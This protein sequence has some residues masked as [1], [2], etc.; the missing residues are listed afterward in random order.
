MVA[1]LPSRILCL[2]TD[3]ERAGGQQQLLRIAQD[4][5][6]GGV[7]MVQVRAHQVAPD[8]LLELAKDVVD[9]V[10]DEALVVV[11][12]TPEIAI[13]SGA[14]GVHFRESAAMDRTALPTNLLAGQSVHSL[15]SA[16]TVEAAGA[17][18]LVLGTIF[19]SQSHPGGA[20]GGTELVRSVA[21]EVSVPVIGIGGI[22]A[23]NAKEVIE[24]DAAGVAVIG[25]I[26]SA[27]DPFEAARTLAEV[28]G[29]RD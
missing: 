2:V 13:Q 15:Q 9:A 1:K 21:S 25:A 23:E 17:D 18:Y 11:N 7:N 22:T 6:R 29:L 19:P 20:T 24:A 27:D 3:V 12:S 8:T 5:V 4:A 16:K 28:I 10:G 14:A 26:I